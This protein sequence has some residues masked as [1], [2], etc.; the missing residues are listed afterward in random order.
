MVSSSAAEHQPW[1]SPL[2]RAPTTP[3]GLR[4]RNVAGY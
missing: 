2:Y 1:T 3:A 4:W